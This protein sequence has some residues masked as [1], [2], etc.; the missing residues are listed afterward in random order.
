VV[1]ALSRCANVKSK[2][3]KK[4]PLGHDIPTDKETST[5]N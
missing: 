2:R 4:T 3:R 5:S 1:E